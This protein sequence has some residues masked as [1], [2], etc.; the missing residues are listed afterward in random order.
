MWLS[1]LNYQIGQVEFYDISQYQEENYPVL[2]DIVDEDLV[3]QCWLADNGFNLDEVEYMVTNEAPNL[4]NGNL[5][6]VIDILL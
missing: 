1:I 4:Y 2:D 3:A 5:Q 6:T